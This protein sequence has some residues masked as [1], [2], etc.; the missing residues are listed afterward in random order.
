MTQETVTLSMNAAL[1]RN[2]EAIHD[3]GRFAVMSKGEDNFDVRVDGGWIWGINQ[4]Q[5]TAILLG[6]DIDPNSGWR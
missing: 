1:H 5:L 6:R 2:S 3:D 4:E